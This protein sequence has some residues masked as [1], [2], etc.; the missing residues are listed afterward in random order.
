MKYF[1]KSLYWL[2]IL[3]SPFKPFSVGFYAGK[4]RIGTPYF[5]PRRT[6]KATPKL[7]AEAAAK[8]IREAERWNKSNPDYARTIKPFED[9]YK[10]KMRYSYF[11][12]MKVG[13]SYC[14]LGYKTKWTRT[15]Y[16][17]EWNPVFSF[18]F[19]G[20]QLA[21]TIYS[22]EM[23]HYWEPWLY[24]YHDTDKTKSRRER[25]EECRKEFPQTWTSHKHG[26]EPVTTD[27][28]TKI[29]KAKY[30]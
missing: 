15:D 7:A 23:S 18:V 9:V 27:Y 17:H 5:L 28:Y 1:F 20:Y 29:I 25:I 12:P 30:L 22:K 10:E 19:F 24:Y 13:F 8:E 16:R 14:G 2:R 6:V 26:E 11:V 4:T 21:I 3:N